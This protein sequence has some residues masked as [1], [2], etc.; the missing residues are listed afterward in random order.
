M[1][2][3]ELIE[4]AAKA[5]GEAAWGVYW[6]AIPAAFR[7]RFVHDAEI[8]WAVFEKAQCKRCGKIAE[9]YAFIGDDRY[10]HPDYGV[11]C[12]TLASHELTSLANQ[13]FI[14]KAQA[15]TDD[16]RDELEVQDLATVIGNVVIDYEDTGPYSKRPIRIRDTCADWSMEIAGEV[17]AAGFR[18]HTQTERSPEFD[19]LEQELFKHQPVLSMRDGSIAGCQCLD[20]VF[21]K[22]T[23]DWGTHLAEVFESLR[24]AHTEPTG[25][26]VQAAIQGR[27]AAFRQNVNATETHL[28]R[29]ALK[30]AF[31]AGQEEQS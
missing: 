31:T 29:A 10:C 21:H 23:E 19:S 14:E 2:R 26:Q 8:A 17:Q 5:A 3:E 13:A 7:E 9:G 16:E 4:E 15:P 27:Y 1:T 28:M 25:A 22:D 18:R 24:P 6:L 20:R 11:D 30:A 12:Y